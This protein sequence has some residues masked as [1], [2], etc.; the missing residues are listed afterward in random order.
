MR[1]GPDPLR[2]P[3]RV[4]GR[5]PDAVPGPPGDGARP[6]PAARDRRPARHGGAGWRAPSRRWASPS[7]GRG[8]GSGA[9]SSPGW[10]CSLWA[11]RPRPSRPRSS[12]C[13]P[14]SSRSAPACRRCWR[15]ASRRSPPGRRPRGG[16]RSSPG[17]L[18]GQPAAWVLGMPVIGLV[19]HHE[20]RLAW[21]AVPLCRGAR[22]A[23]PRGGRRRLRHAGSGAAARRLARVAP[24]RRPRLG[25]RRGARLPRLERD[26]PATSVRC[27][28]RATASRP[29]RSASCSAAVPPPTSRRVARAASRRRAC[30]GRC[31][32]AACLAAAVLSAALGLLRSSLAI[33]AVLVVALMLLNGIRGL[34]GSALGLA[35]APD[36]SVELTGLRAAAVQ[37]G[38]LLGAALGGM[39]LD[40][41]G[42]GAM[43]TVFAVAFVSL[44]CPRARAAILSVCTSRSWARCWWSTTERRARSP[45]AGC[46]RCWPG[47]RSTPGVPCPTARWPTPCG[48]AT[49]PRDVQHALQSLVSRLRRAL[50]DPALVVQEPAGYR[51]ALTPDSVDALRFERLA[52]EGAAAL[53]A[54]DPAGAGRLLAEALDLWRG[55]PVADALRLHDVRL[56]ARID[57]L[58]AA[59]EQG[60]AAEHVAELTELAD[61]H[62]LHERLGALRMRRAGRV[63]G[64][65]ADALAAYEALR[66]A[67]DDE[68]GATPS[69]VLQEAHMAVLMGEVA[70]APAPPPR[71]NLPRGADELR[72][73][74]GGPAAGLGS[75]LAASARDA[76][77]DRAARARRGSPLELAARAPGTSWL[78]ELAPLGDGESLAP[79]VL[80]AL[81]L[82]EATLP[83][84]RT[85]RGRRGVAAAR[86][87]RRE[88]R[89]ARARQLRAHRR[90]RRGAR[91]PAARRLPRAAD[92]RDEP[93]AARR[94]AARRSPRSAPLERGARGAAVRRPRRVGDARLRARRDDR[95]G[96][97]GVCRR[98]DGLPLAIELAAA[99]LRSMSL[100]GARRPPRRPLPPAHRRQ[101]RRAPAG[102]GRCARSST[103]AG[104]CSSEPERRLA[105]RL[106]VFP[107][108]ATLD[109]VEAV[110]AGD[111]VDADE[112][113]DLLCALVDR[114]LLGVRGAG[115]LALADARDDPRVR[116]G[117]GRARG[118][119][120]RACARRTRAHFTAL[121]QQ[122]DAHL[123][124]PDQLPWL[125]R[126]RDDRDNVLSAVRF[127]GETGGARDRAADRHDAPVV[128]G[129]R[130]QPRGRARVAALRAVGRGRR[131]P[132]RP[133]ARRGDRR[134]E[135]PRRAARRP[136]RDA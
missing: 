129:A 98:L 11:A 55:E 67:L 30:P 131:G 31:S 111:G 69:A 109:A 24:A 134:L 79:A 54:G 18:V 107:A 63:A 34:S 36:R 45:A 76:R 77:R 93:R 48:R 61:E 8:S 83:D 59:A 44:P 71:G 133:A 64:R 17:P 97:R 121:V 100:A 41:G 108:G 132:V 1:P 51:L 65:Q 115:T 123:R 35:I 110:C 119:A 92:P 62:P 78:V 9:C 73:P 13:S 33:T 43:T 70:V 124:G 4:A 60:A 102:S 118:R 88:R 125:A 10:R 2:V 117:G 127:L 106:S 22:R 89:A 95:A 136:A 86:R 3:V 7:R 96:R 27:S 113:F 56:A 47:W 42:T 19:A 120:G 38:G 74:R 84:R 15:A 87:A 90:G 128:L 116:R 57:L 66:A 135:R 58:T 52:R 130:R 50:G 12:G 112:V 28:T 72:R 40:V 101:P 114:S 21:L 94:S 91:R 5:V 29:S 14:P 68:L 25:G 6:G 49:R 26:A 46:R 23:R 32:T 20:W 85:A 126:L 103:G 16:R 53:R 39:A 82:R 75:A 37:T 99:R 105:R 80:G 81:G 104:T 122:A